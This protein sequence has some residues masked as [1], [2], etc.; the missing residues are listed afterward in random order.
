[1][2]K[3]KIFFASLKKTVA[4]KITAVLVFA[5]VLNIL[6]L[7]AFVSL[8]D[9]IMPGKSVLRLENDFGKIC[10]AVSFPIKIV[11]EMFKKSKE[12]SNNSE[13]KNKNINNK[14]FALLVPVKHAKKSENIL[15]PDIIVPFSGGK[16][17]FK[18]VFA[19]L[20]D[21][22]LKYQYMIRYLA[23]T[24]FVPYM[25]LFL[26]IMLLLPRGVPVKIRNL[27]NMVFTYP[28]FI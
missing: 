8:R 23:D 2:I 22:P 21:M 14:L 4:I 24:D 1:M 9:S 26:M 18:S 20:Y 6:N 28:A 25:L 10:G 16:V 11:N 12:M 7:G 17:L 13:E 3:T 15:Q 27:I 19:G 5:M